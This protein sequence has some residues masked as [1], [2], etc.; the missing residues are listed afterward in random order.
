MIDR[1]R[2]LGFR[3]TEINF[4]SSPT[5]AGQYVNKRG[6]MWG[7]LKAWLEAGGALPPVPELKADLCAVR[8]DFDAAGRLRLGSK[9]ALKARTGRSPD[10]ADALALTFALPV[11]KQTAQA[12]F[13]RTEYEVL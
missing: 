3:V 13:A 12:S 9:D 6:E 5:K 7:D 4:G 10:L 8:Y 2:Q 1:V 11:Q